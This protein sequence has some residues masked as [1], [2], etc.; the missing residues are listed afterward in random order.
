MG[1]A[2]GIISEPYRV[3]EDYP[4]WTSDDQKTEA[5]TWRNI[6]L[7]P[8]CARAEAKKGM[9]DVDWGAITL[10]GVYI[11]PNTTLRKYEEW[12]EGIAGI[13]AKRPS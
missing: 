5:I 10:V 4:C 8:P 1:C 2:I 11:S 7:S 12:L 6:S 9:I 13:I 3:P